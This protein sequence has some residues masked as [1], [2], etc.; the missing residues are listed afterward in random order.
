MSIYIALLL[1]YTMNEREDSLYETQERERKSLNGEKSQSWQATEKSVI[2]NK[3]GSDVWEQFMQTFSIRSQ[4]E[5]FHS[6]IEKF[7]II[8]EIFLLHIFSDTLFRDF[9]MA[10]RLLHLF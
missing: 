8:P 10:S 5:K 1:S 2:N 6:P 3:E 4:S 7:L 9:F